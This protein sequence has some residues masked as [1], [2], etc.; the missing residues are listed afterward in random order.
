MSYKKCPFCN[1]MI[2]DNM[3]QCPYCGEYLP[4]EEEKTNNNK[5]TEINKCKFCKSILPVGATKCPHCGEWQNDKIANTIGMHS[6]EIMS[7]NLPIIAGICGK[8]L[9]ILNWINWILAIILAF[10]TFGLS[11]LWGLL[12]W[13][14]IFVIEILV[15]LP[16]AIAEI[17]G[18]KTVAIIILLMNI[19]FGATIIVPIIGWVWAYSIEG[20]VSWKQAMSKLGE[21]NKSKKV[22]SL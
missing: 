14:G 4:K 16:V 21:N 13:I 8:G 5:P 11:L 3:E 15:V 19:F 7:D 2:H 10:F 6:T 12:A 20:N 9:E 17:K 18:Q 1:E 22:N